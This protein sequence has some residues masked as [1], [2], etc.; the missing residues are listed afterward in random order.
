M[1][2]EQLAIR[3]GALVDSEPLYASILKLIEALSSGIGKGAVADQLQLTDTF[4]SQA[5]RDRNRCS[6]KALHLV[7]LILLDDGDTILEALAQA[8]GKTLHRR[9][10]KTDAEKV[11]ALVSALRRKLGELGEAIAAEALK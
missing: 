11:E 2:P 4:F 6:F 8:K 7:A 9:R 5:L 3:F 10:Q 1:S